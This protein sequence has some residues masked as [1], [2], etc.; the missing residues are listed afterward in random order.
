MVK[1]SY[2]AGGEGADGVVE[3]AFV[4]LVVAVR[5]SKN[6]AEGALLVPLDSW[7]S[8]LTSCR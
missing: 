1:T 6:P 4:S 7:T 5:D 8:F 3:V 2:R